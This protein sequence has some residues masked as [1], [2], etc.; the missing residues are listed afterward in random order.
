MSTK[1]R[2]FPVQGMGCAACVARVE[3][4][5]K[6]CK[7]VSAVNVSL[8]SNSAQVD[9]DPAVVTPGEMKKAVQDA[10]YDMLVDG[11]DDEADSEAEIAR[12]DAFSTLRK[13]TILACVLAALVMLL[14]MG[15]EDFPGK[16]F[17]LW[18]LATP[19]V[20][21]CGRRFFKAGFSALRHGSANMDTLVALSVSI[22]YL[23]SVFNLLFPQVWTSQGLEAH[24]YFESA[25]MIVAFIL[26]GRLLEE[27]AKHSTTAAI[28]K[29]MGLQEKGSTARPGETVLVKPGERLAVDGLVTDG[30]SY[31]DE[32]T[33]TGEPVPALKQAGSHVYA[34]T[35]NQNG[36]LTVKVEKV[37]ENTL[38]SGIIRMVRDAQGS[39]A[40]IQ[41]TVDRIAAVFV[42]VIIGISVLTLL[43]WILCGDVTLGLLAMVTVLVIACPCS[44][45][46]ATPTAI[47]AGIGNGASKGILIKD[48]ESLQV[49]RKVQAMVMD[50]TGTLTEGKP[51]V[52]E[53]VWDPTILTEDDPNELNLRDVLYALEHRSEH[54]LALAVCESLRGCEDLPVEDF[55]AILGKGIAGTVHGTRY[56][57]GNMDLLH[58]IVGD[59]PEATN[60]MV[61]DSIGPWMD[62]GYT[63][64]LLFDKVKVYAVLALADE[65][66]DTSVQAVKA[67]Q[68]QGIEIHMLTGDNEVAARHIAEETGIAHVKAHVLPQ[69]KAEYV[70]RLQASGKRV[71]MVGDGINDSAALAQADLGIA[72]GQ[73]SDI[74]IDT[75]QVTIVSSDLSKL[76]DLVRLSKRTVTIIR[77][78]LF[79]AFFYNLL[80]VPLAAGI[81][82]P[83]N[84]FLLNPMVAAA[85]MALS[86]VC[87]VTNS[88]RLRK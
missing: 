16:G 52:V 51:S 73:G 15:F 43:I 64:T 2:N 47:I 25:T 66:K 79:W 6:A 35:I 41:K 71:A 53:S 77:E 29:L 55:Q 45:G 72:M 57:V 33:L 56:Y 9:Y 69:D 8:A 80:A 49:A 67:L 74:A 4:T 21:W 63:V 37:G 31:V 10:G 27:R 75:A 88:L 14:S 26:I 22:S 78:N 24:L 18:A 34:G 76:S 1:R 50:K 5:L 58:D 42:P 65:L 36:A 86:S 38:L 84:G 17:V 11:S 19:V 54:P 13:D 28:R 20:F 83:V 46:L 40:P 3:N 60:P 68:A 30:S 12:Q 82:Y 39:K 61:G 62:A 7:G 23:F 59:I 48:A 87:V 85:C 44:L 81:L 70:K 32:S